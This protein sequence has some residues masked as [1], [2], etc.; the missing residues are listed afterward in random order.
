MV[1]KI[2]YYINF[3]IIFFIVFIIIYIFKNKVVFRID[4]I[5][6]KGFKRIKDT[7]G[8]Y[9]WV[10]KMGDGKTYSL[11]DWLDEK[12]RIDN[13]KIITNVHSYHINHENSLYFDNF[14]DIVKFI[15]DDSPLDDKR[16]YIIFFDELFTLLE[17]G[18]L[19]KE[20]LSFISQLRKRGIYLCTTVQEWLDINVTFRRYCRFYIECKMF[21]K[22]GCTWSVNK[23]HS[24]Y[25]MK[26]NNDINEYESPVIKTTV[27]KCSLDIANSYD[28]LE[29]I[30][31]S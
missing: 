5:F 27:K 16:N 6:R 13:K 11:C 3:F 14:Y 8:V 15:N 25:D 21:D 19:N 17:K 23:I 26:W 2:N 18:K 10:G 22:F 20:I 12:T 1:T 7:Y 31:T 4:T 29:I 28:T 9:C 24:G 30:K